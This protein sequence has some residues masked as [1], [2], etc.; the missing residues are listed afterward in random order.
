MKMKSARKTRKAVFVF[1]IFSFSVCAMLLLNKGLDYF[2]HYKAG[3]VMW[4]NGAILTKDVFSFLSQGKNVYWMS[5]EWLQE[6][7]LFGFSKISPTYHI[8]LYC[9]TFLFLLLF[10]LYKTREKDYQKNL[11]FS[12]LFLTL[13]IIVVPNLVMPRPMMISNLLLVLT[14]Y[15]L[16]DFYQNEKSNK[17]WFLPLLSILWAN[18]HGG[19]S[20]LSYLLALVFAFVSMLSFSYTK[21]ECKRKTRQQTMTFLLIA[22]LS[23]LTIAINPHGIKMWLYP[24]Q[25]MGNTL[26]LQGIREWAPTTVSEPV[27]LVFFAFLLFLCFLLL[28]SKKKIQGIDLA[29]LLIFTYLGLK[30]IRFWGYLYFVSNF[31]IFDYIEAVKKEE[32][33]NG[34]LILLSLFLLGIFF[35][36]LSSL[37]KALMKTPIS[38]TMLSVVS[39]ENPK[40]LF[41]YYDYGG[42]LIQNEIPV[43][44]DG[45]ADFYSEI[46]TYQDYKTLENAR[47]SAKIEKLLEKYAFDFYLLPKDIGL[48]F[49]LKE[50]DYPIVY[51][52]EDVVFFRAKEDDVS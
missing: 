26:M 17:I 19:S 15:L 42:Y 29:L 20:N 38:S 32:K 36:Q 10:T 40:R 11:P 37:Q 46:G 41:N 2:W 27:H 24:Y 1:F 45:R 21:M 6:V 12:L 3:E 5:H 4:K 16:Y 18:V 33:T 31:F 22:F 52:E 44:V 23:F 30:S 13:S 48:Y 8:V 51:E 14:L 7:I 25:N 43:F 35:F 50:K 9:F 39:E 28:K 34:L 47:R 49:Y